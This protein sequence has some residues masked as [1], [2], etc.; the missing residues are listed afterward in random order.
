MSR[1][2]DITTIVSG[3]QT[4]AD[5][6]ALDVALAWNLSVRGW[7]PRGRRAEDGV[8]SARYPNL[9]ET[10]DIDTAERTRLNVRDSDGCLI[11]SHGALTGGSRL[12][13]TTALEL[14]RPLLHVDL[15]S[16]TMADAVRA[17]AAWVHEHRVREP[18]L[19]GPRASEDPHIY[20]ATT[21][22]LS[23]LLGF[24]LTP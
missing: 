11:V 19:G 15:S 24:L 10:A 5:R 20:A 16:T 22:L 17:A 21:V 8:I 1:R 13:E 12:A 2:W 7:V 6:A 4:G 18:G 3:G 14:G 23:G 9:R